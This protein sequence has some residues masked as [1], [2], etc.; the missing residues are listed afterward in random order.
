MI[1]EKDETVYAHFNIVALEIKPGTLVRLD[2]EPSLTSFEK[3]LMESDVITSC[4]QLTSLVASN[5]GVAQA[6]LPLLAHHVES[7]LI[8]MQAQ[9]EAVT[10]CEFVMECLARLPSMICIAVASKVRHAFI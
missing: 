6:P 5:K 1:L 10:S 7:A 8:R 4:S 9:D 2:P 3:A